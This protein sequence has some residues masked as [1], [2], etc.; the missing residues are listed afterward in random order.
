WTLKLWIWE[1]ADLAFIVSPIRLGTFALGVLL[2]VLLYRRITF[3]GKLTVTFWIGVLA[4]IAWIVVEGILNFDPD[5]AFDFSGQAA[6]WPD[7]FWAGLGAAMILAMYS[8]LGYYNVCYMGDEVRNP[9][10]TIPRAILLSAVMVCVLFVL[11]HLAMLG[12]VSWNN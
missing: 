10:R 6:D 8:Y 4:A 5:V 7:D 1:E 12:A 11:L 2:L 9:G 3:S